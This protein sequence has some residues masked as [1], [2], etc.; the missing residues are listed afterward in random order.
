M[1]NIYVR[2]RTVPLAVE[3]AYACRLLAATP[4]VRRALAF[5]LAHIHTHYGRLVERFGVPM[6]RP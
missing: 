5:A 6:S 1:P 2:K 3:L 4:A